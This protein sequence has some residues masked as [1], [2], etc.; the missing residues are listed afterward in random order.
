MGR[1]FRNL[2]FAALAA[3]V[4]AITGSAQQKIERMTY[5]QRDAALQMLEFVRDT[6][7]SRYYDP[8]FHGVDFNARYQ[9]AKDKVKQA[10]TLSEAYAITAWMLE[11]LEDSHTVFFPML[12]EYKIENGWRMKFIGDRCYITAVEP[13]SDA[14]V[15]G[16][17][18]GDEVLEM[19]GFRIDRETVGKLFYSIEF[20]APRSVIHL[21]VAEP[22][23]AAR[24]L[25]VKANVQKV[26]RVLGFGFDLRDQDAIRMQKG[27]M[28]EIGNALMIWKM[29]EF[30]FDEK[31]VDRFISSAKKT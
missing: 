7:K 19:E 28:V 12:P 10:D 18:P 8:R 22:N 21:V 29:P 14:A 15:Q 16:L 17:T 1:K 11:P 4:C 6:V 2:R 27:R 26:S 3:L 31:E 23:T 20:L 24:E 25:V 30:G 13:G 9:A 5:E